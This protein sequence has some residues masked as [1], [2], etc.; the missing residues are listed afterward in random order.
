MSSKWQPRTTRR[1]P[2]PWCKVG[3]FPYPPLIPGAS[4][5]K[6]AS[7]LV[8][9]DPD[10]IQVSDITASLILFWDEDAQE[11]SN[12]QTDVHLGVGGKVTQQPG[13]NIF[14]LEVQLW[15]DGEYSE[16]TSFSDVPMGPDFP[17]DSDLQALVVEAGVHWTGIRIWA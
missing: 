13:K 12:H 2:P 5:L 7:Y 16:G 15:V 8:W 9:K 14:D 10:P 4:P 3:L 17:W 6:L 1:V 11:W